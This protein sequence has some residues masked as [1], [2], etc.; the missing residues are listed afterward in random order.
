[1]VTIVPP[2]VEPE[3]GEMLLIVGGGA[4]EAV[5]V[6]A[7]DAVPFC[8]SGFVTTTLTAPVGWAGVT[9][10]IWVEL[11]TVTDDAALPPKDTTAPDWKFVPVM[12]TA[13]PPEAGPELGVKPLTVGGA[14]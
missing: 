5:Y 13:V 2:V 11:A 14:K 7:L 1:M 4:V 3:V 12:V 6:K 8:P 10:W 9:V